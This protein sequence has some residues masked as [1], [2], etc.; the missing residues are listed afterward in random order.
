[1]GKFIKSTGEKIKYR[2]CNYPIGMSMKTYLKIMFNS[3]GAS[4]S[5]V[6]ERLQSLGFR[7]ITGAYDMVYEWDNGATVKDAIWFADKVH[8][9]LKG[10]KVLFELETISE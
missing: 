1:M 9:T 5:E 10:F 6:M 7:P 8:E 3:E 2:L 4:P